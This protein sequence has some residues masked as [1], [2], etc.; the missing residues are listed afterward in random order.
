[1]RKLTWISTALCLALAFSACH[2]EKKAKNF[3]QKTTLD[4]NGV[5]FVMDAHEAGLT[6]INAGN[7]AEKNSKN[8]RVIGLAKMMVADHTAAGAELDTIAKNNLV[9]VADTLTGMHKQMLNDLSKKAG[10]DFDKA[11]MQ[12]MVDDH[13]KVIDLFHHAQENTNAALKNYSLKISPKLQVH[14]DSAKAILS[15]LK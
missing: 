4:D 10:A 5:K 15:S 1:M 14:L 8:P 6:E 13:G 3:N 9:T 7:L 11:Y 12:M 2:D